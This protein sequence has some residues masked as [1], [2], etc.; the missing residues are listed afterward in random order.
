MSV[1]NVLTDVVVRHCVLKVTKCIHTLTSR[2]PAEHTQV[3]PV[4]LPQISSNRIKIFTKVLRNGWFCEKKNLHFS[5]QL[6]VLEILG[7]TH[8]AGSFYHPIN[9]IKQMDYVSGFIQFALC[10]SADI[11]L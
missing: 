7:S 5:R 11:F 9:S 10:A 6:Y 1:Q 4:G 2:I 8:V 3:S